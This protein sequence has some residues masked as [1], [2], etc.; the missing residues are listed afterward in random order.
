MTE[1]TTLTEGTKYDGDKVRIE[2]FPGE[3][4]FAISQVLTFG[5]KKYADRNWEKGI[6]WS[7]VFGACMRHMWCWWQGKSPTATNFVFGEL[8][9]ETRFSHLWHAGCCIAFL[10]SYEERKMSEFD[11]RPQ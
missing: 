4:L 11:D 8:D 6:K 9:P 10:I 1:T 5:A 7:R 2:L 3:A